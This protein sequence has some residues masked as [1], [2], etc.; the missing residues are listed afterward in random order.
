MK[1]NLVTIF[2][3]GGFLGRQVAQALMARGARVR[4]AQRDLANSVKVKALGNLGQTQFVAANRHQ[5]GRHPQRRFRR[6]PA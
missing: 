2:G 3:G 6:G 1:D 5:P 4:I